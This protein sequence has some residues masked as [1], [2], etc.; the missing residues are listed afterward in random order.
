MNGNDKTVDS[1]TGK[2]DSRLPWMRE[3]SPQPIHRNPLR[4]GVL[5]VIVGVIL[6]GVFSLWLISYEKPQKTPQGNSAR[7]V[8]RPQIRTEKQAVKE[9][10]TKVVSAEPEPQPQATIP[11]SEKIVET[12]NVT[13][14]VDGSVTE[15]F[16]TADGKTHSIKRAP[17]HIFQDATDDLIAM[18]IS[19]MN[20]G[21]TMPPMPMG[22][23][24]DAQFLKSLEHAIIPYDD[25]PKDVQELKRKVNEVR[26]QIKE[27][28]DQGESFVSIMRKHQDIVNASVP[29]RDFCQHELKKMLDAGD[30]QGAEEYLKEANKKLEQFGYEAVSMPESSAARRARIRAEHGKTN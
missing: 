26:I 3:D 13:T 14:N 21:S 20:S 9:S 2:T 24:M 30:V 17:K 16:R 12:L 4:H 15:R 5:I 27:L 29:L 18:A 6:V 10:L 11:D 8:Q 7:K 19:G 23:N 1:H 25:D 28:M 22:D